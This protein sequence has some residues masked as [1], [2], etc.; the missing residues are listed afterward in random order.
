MKPPRR[1]LPVTLDRLTNRALH[2]LERFSASEKSLRDVL[3]RRA[4]P[5]GRLHGQAEPDIR[6]MVE[7]VVTRLRE[8]GL[9]DDRRF[10]E[11][12]AATLAR[13]GRSARRIRDT[14]KSKGIEGSLIAAAMAVAD[15][16]ADE[17]TRAH[18]FARRRRLGPYRQPP[19]PGRRMKDLA[20]MARAGF[21]PDTARRV[22]DGE[23]DETQQAWAPI[24][25]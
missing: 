25:G 24:R 11:G 13:T 17:L 2:Y 3:M 4:R 21:A 8:G 22:I 9:L 5:A 1:P 14:L 6:A 18:A 16:E 12:R 19:D 23:S 10:A 7:Q 20:A 15:R